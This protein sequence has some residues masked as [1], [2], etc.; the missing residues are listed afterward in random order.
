MFD[1]LVVMLRDVSKNKFETV[2][3]FHLSVTNLF[4]TSGLSFYMFLQGSESAD[5]FKTWYPPLEKTV[6]CLSK[7]YRCL[8]R[9]VFTGL[10]QVS[11]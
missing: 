5:V 10:A 9:A 7:I 1:D 2:A 8:E 4:I 3:L 6:S 11:T